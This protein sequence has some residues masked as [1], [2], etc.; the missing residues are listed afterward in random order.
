MKLNGSQIVGRCLQ[1]EGVEVIFG[2]PGGAIMPLYDHMDKF[3][4]RHVLV[5][6]EQG[7]AH[8]AD[9]YARVKRNVGVCMG[10][11]GPGATNLVTGIL[12]AHMDSSPVVA[13][14][15]NVAT[16]F[17][18]SDAFQEA[19]INGITI[20]VTKQNYLV[21]HV[22]DLARSMKEAFY[23]ARTGRP[24]P[25]H[26]DIPKDV[27]VAETDFHYPDKVELPGF[28][29]S[30]EGNMVQV[31]KAARL[32]EQAERPVI[33]SGQ[34]TLISGA[35]AELKALA[36]KAT[37]P[38]ITTLLGISAFPETHPLSLQFPGMHGWVWANYAIHH[39]DLVIGIGNRFDDRCCGKYSAFAPDA[40]IIH[41]DIDPAEIGKNIRTDV[42][43]V[44]DVKRV[45][46][47]LVPEIG[48]CADKRAWL[49]QIDEWR[50]KYPPKKYP[51]N[52]PVVYQPQV[53]SALYQATRGDAII[54]AD[55]GQHQMFAA[56]HYL[57]DEPNS[58]ITSGGLG[59]MG[60]SLP[61]S[62]GAWFARPDKTVWCVAGDGSFQMTM[63][64]LAVMVVEK[65]P[66]KVA[67]INNASLGMVRQWQELFYAG[68]YQAVDLTG[69]PD[70]VKLAQAYGIPAW[71]V[72]KP[73]E[74]QPAIGAAMA[75]PGPALIDFQVAKGEN[76]LPMVVPGTAL[77]EVIPDEAYVG[78]DDGGWPGDAQP[79]GEPVQA[80][81]LRH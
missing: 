50:Q 43:I 14:T 79:R 35:S 30:L 56:Q 45:L 33:L 53:I 44:G 67:V 71:R 25:V 5:R 60:F 78:G 16:S 39:S 62:I 17:I 55:V 58:F 7:A 59:T 10:T 37:L 3:P 52:T 38:V 41:I 29:P 24:G 47:K 69:P 12:N 46:Q 23:I 19:D 13:I 68:N 70:Y 4:A 22:K 2:L 34:G 66:V 61:A 75:Y 65:V 8:M 63:Q 18:G 28:Q 73:H 57:Y 1:E 31:R 11:S 27:L 26:I 48:K 49:R 80:A 32:I 51:D 54:V 74:L 72:T 77:S 20:P 36:E 9:G 21:R 42:P 64:E 81:G 6:H 76:V 15:A 40:K